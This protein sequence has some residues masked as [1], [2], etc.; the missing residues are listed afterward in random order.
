M[1]D[2]RDS[3]PWETIRFG[4]RI[5]VGAWGAQIGL[6]IASRLLWTLLISAMRSSS[7]GYSAFSW[8]MGVVSLILQMAH[9]AVGVT[10][11]VAASRLTRFPLILREPVPA[12]PYRGPRDGGP[13]PDPGLDGLAVVLVAVLATSAGL[14]LLSYVVST[15]L[16]YFFRPDPGFGV[17]EV[18]GILTFASFLVG[19]VVFVIWA[20]RAARAVGRSLPVALVITALAGLAVLAGFDLWFQLDHQVSR[21]HP[22]S[23]WVML[24]LNVATTGVLMAIALNL[25]AAIR[26]QP[27][28]LGA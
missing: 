7:S 16:S 4:L 26:D 1:S 10:L 23:L 21:A 14:G 2:A 13:A 11:A 17:R 8:V 20:S 18:I 25:L 9:V 22:W 6:S 27:R 3:A 19:P 5:F 28:E 12:D 24:G 15:V